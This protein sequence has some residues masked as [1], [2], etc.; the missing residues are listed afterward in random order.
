MNLNSMLSVLWL[1]QATKKTLIDNITSH[2]GK[3]WIRHTYILF[4]NGL[5][6][7]LRYPPEEPTS[8]GWWRSTSW[9]SL[10]YRPKT[11]RTRQR[12][13]AT[14]GWHSPFQKKSTYKIRAKSHFTFMAKLIH[15]TKIKK[16]TKLKTKTQQT[17][18]WKSFLHDHTVLIFL[19]MF[20]SRWC[21]VYPEECG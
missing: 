20:E 9:R 11:I 1:T 12:P 14:I 19:M 4:R 18:I 10:K 15:T 3:K 2:K 21:R 6:T 5:R 7:Q 16:C 17:K 8:T 13:V